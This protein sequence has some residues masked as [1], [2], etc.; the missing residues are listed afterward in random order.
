MKTINQLYDNFIKENKDSLWE[1]KNDLK[2]YMKMEGTIKKIINENLREN[3]QLKYR[4]LI[5]L[6]KIQEMHDIAFETAKEFLKEK[7]LENKYDYFLKEFK[8][9]SLLIKSDFFIEKNLEEEFNYDFIELNKLQF[10]VDPIQFYT[11]KKIKIRFFNSEKQSNLI[12]QY[13]K[14][15]GSSPE[16]L[17]YILSRCDINDFYK[18]IEKINQNG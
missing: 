17:G 3:E 14:Q 11:S 5:I 13:V 8:K 6:E 18:K 12:S 15:H 9:F 10:K 2:K 4:A 16:G 1:S 7:D